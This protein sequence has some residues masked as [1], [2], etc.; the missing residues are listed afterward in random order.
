MTALPI[1]L[2]CGCRRYEEYLRAAIRRAERQVGWEVIGVVG[3]IATEPMFDKTTRILTLPVHDTYEA[4]PAKLHA[5]FAWIAKHRSF[6]GI[7]KTDDDIVF[8]NVALINTICDRIAVPY[9]GVKVSSC[10]AGVI[11]SSRVKQR[12]TD[13]TM[14]PSY[15]AAIY[16][17]GAGYWLSP[18]ALTLILDAKTEY[19][20][21]IIEDICTGAVLNQAG[22]V[23]KRVI[24]PY[25]EVQRIPDLLR[26]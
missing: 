22:I 1:L 23:P 26:R 9:W 20:A 21:A 6:S 11:D 12:F 16:C 18:K 2:I 17:H 7:F 14:K 24:V 4:L 8:D 5:A 19:D 15:P 10:S 13:T 3:Q 25:K